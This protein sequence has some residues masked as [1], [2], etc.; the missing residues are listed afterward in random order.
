MKKFLLI[1]LLIFSVSFS[2]SQN[3]PDFD[4]ANLALITNTPQLISKNKKFNVLVGGQIKVE[5]N[6]DEYQYKNIAAGDFFV[7]DENGLIQRKYSNGAGMV[8]FTYENNKLVSSIFYGDYILR[9]P[10]I[11]FW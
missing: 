10:I 5:K 9:Q 7:Y 11:H 6:F 2:Y 4:L 3:T 8:T 1:T